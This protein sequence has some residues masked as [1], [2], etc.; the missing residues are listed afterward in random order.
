MSIDFVTLVALARDVANINAETADLEAE[1]DRDLAPFRDKM[2]RLNASQVEQRRR[3][4]A[5]YFALQQAVRGGSITLDELLALSP[6]EDHDRMREWY[7]REAEDR[8]ARPVRRRPGR[9]RKVSAA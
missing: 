9:P 6:A 1:V 8:A 2:A 3:G 4:N 7:Q 5:L